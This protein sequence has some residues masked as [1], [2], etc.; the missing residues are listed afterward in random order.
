MQNRHGSREPMS[1]PEEEL[2]HD[3]KGIAAFLGVSVRTAQRYA[4]SR[5]LPVYRNRTEQGGSV[6]YA[7]KPDLRA[8]LTGEAKRLFQ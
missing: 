8:W 3:W 4:S 1:R 5:S 2:V 7:F 6:V